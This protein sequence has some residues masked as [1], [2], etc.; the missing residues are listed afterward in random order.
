MVE[1]VLGRMAEWF[2]AAVLKT[3]VP[4][5]ENGE[6]FCSLSIMSEVYRQDVLAQCAHRAQEKRFRDGAFLGT[7]KDE[8]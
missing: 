8:R 5:R 4:D 6:R 3:A 2:K 7:T 1:K